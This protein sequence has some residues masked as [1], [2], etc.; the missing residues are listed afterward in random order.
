MIPSVV[1][2][3]R[4]ELGD[5]YV[6]GL[7]RVAIGLLLFWHALGAARELETAGY[8]GDA[9]HMPFVPESWVPSRHVYTWLTAARVLLAVLVTVGYAPRFAL[10]ASALLGVYVLLCDRVGYHH[11]RYAL[12]CFAFL[13][14]FA[15]CDHA[16][17]IT[18]PPT[19]ATSRRGL[20][21]AQRLAQ[22]Q[23]S[24]IYLASGG[25]KLLDDDW[26][27]GRVIFDRFARYSY[28]AIERGVPAGLVELLSQPRM[29]SALA[30]L[31][32]ATE[33]F[34][35]IALWARR[36]RVAALW[37]GVMFHL[38]IEVTSKV[39]IFTWLTLAIYGLFVTPDVG[40]RKLFFDPSRIKG[41][42]LSRLVIA[43]D[44]LA[45]FDVKAWEPDA[46]KKG[47]VIVVVRRDGTRA[48]GVR[49]LAMVAR[50]VPLL[51]P[52]WAPLALVA[53]FTKGGEASGQA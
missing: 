25:S 49:A 31:A 8:F 16:F 6:L 11:N 17:I 34:L 24:I 41:V 50:C 36:T 18:G 45:R 10:F 44:W 52:L 28:Q 26:R 21:W 12:D 23:L 20:L 19:T 14:S 53:S 2:R 4:D 29:T 39:E 27:Y 7:V 1:Q 9:F 13:L 43:L 15:P 37:W 33:L 35:A 5:T 40:A 48:T 3:W 51:F 30:K 46:L 42:V 47:H 22:L 32:I 38:T